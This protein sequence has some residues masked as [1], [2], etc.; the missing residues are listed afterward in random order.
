MVY[1]LIVMCS[2]MLRDSLIV[3]NY[4]LYLIPIGFDLAESYQGGGIFFPF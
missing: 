1:I 4:E 2:H 3:W